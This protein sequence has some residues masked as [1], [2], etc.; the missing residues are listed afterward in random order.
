MVTG[1]GQGVIL[2]SRAWPERAFLYASLREAGLDVL[3]VEHPA[4]A[5]AALWAWPGRFRLVLVDAG[6]FARRDLDRILARAGPGGA[7][8]LVLAGPFESARLPRPSP[9]GLRVV[10]KPVAVAEV[11]EAVVQALG[12]TSG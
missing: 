4:D 2:L 9:P 6:G 12:L 8:V 1:R 11:V 7:D 10:P 3:G 5:E